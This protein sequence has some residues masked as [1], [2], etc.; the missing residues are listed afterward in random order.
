MTAPIV[1]IET[2]WIVGAVM[3]QD[4]AADELLAAP[5]IH[6]VLPSVCLMEA[7]KSFEGKRR[8]RNVLK[9]ALD[10]EMKE[11]RRSDEIAEAKALAAELQEAKLH[12]D[13]LLDALYKRLDVTLARVVQR[14]ELLHPLPEDVT[15]ACDLAL[16]TD[17][18]RADLL[19]L[20]LVRRH[21]KAA[22]K[23]RRAL[24]T[25][26]RPFGGGRPA[27]PR[28]RRRHAFPRGARRIGMGR[29]GEL[30]RMSTRAAS[31]S[32]WWAV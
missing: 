30:S 29:R 20:T 8:S 14:A 11:I 16:L 10:Q 3:G 28:R 26:D 4:P 12:N 24:L 2:N 6:L 31:S 22:A 25:G 18:E 21:A 1:Y 32:R 7:L 9:A 19:I 15:S 5:G 17:G 23:A 13:A 27:A